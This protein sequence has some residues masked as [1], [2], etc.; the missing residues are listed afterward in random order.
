MSI[1]YFTKWVEV[2]PVTTI[3]VERVKRTPLVKWPGQGCQQN[4]PEGIAKTIG[5]GQTRLVQ[6]TQRKNTHKRPAKQG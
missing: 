6:G 4:H 5:R 1:D 2:E 3:S